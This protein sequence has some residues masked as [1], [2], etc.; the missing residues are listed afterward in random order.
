M[1]SGLA[2]ILDYLYNQSSPTHSVSKHYVLTLQH[3]TT[4][5]MDPKWNC[6]QKPSDMRRKNIENETVNAM[7]FSY[8]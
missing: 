4:E 7:M 1:I 5:D 2:A 8:I 3:L 6:S